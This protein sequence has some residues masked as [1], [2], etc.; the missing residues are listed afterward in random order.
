MPNPF[1]GTART[2][3]I[4]NVTQ[5]P[6]TLAPASSQSL[7][8]LSVL[9][10]NQ[11]GVLVR[12]SLVFARRG[13]NIESLVVS[14][15]VTNGDFS[16]MTITCRGDAQTFEQISKQ[17]TKLID[18][19][20]ALDH[21]GQA[22]VETEIGLLKLKTSDMQARTEI[23]QIA[24]HYKAKVIDYGAGS[25]ILRI[26]GESEKVDRFVDLLRPFG[27]VELIRSGKIIMARGPETT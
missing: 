11:P 9:V 21:T 2:T 1:T 15:E 10:R 14:P 8:T 26:Y 6:L 22:T 4:S 24:E 3:D 19:V 27:I 18:V 16:R 13:Y 23:L 12:V 7:H 25:L 17:L 5:F 20:Q